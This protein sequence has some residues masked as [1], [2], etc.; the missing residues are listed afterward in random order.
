MEKVLA[1]IESEIKLG[2]FE[3]TRFFPN[4]L[5]AEKFQARAQNAPQIIGTGPMESGRVTMVPTTPLFREFC[6]EWYL[7]NEIRWKRSYRSTL[8]VTFNK[9]KPHHDAIAYDT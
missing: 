1:R 7:E 2:T 6:D 4:S 8:N 5:L 3:Y 9:Y